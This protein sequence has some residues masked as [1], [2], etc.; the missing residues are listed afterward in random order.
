[1]GDYILAIL[2][3]SRRVDVTGLEFSL[4]LEIRS[5]RSRYDRDLCR[6]SV[7]VSQGSNGG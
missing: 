6:R 5:Y 7:F 2:P 3:L 4:G 1:M